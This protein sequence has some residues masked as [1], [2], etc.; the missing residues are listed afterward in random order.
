MEPLPYLRFF[1]RSNANL[2][3]YSLWRNV[4]PSLT[5]FSWLVAS[6]I[7]HFVLYRFSRSHASFNVHSK[8]KKNTFFW[9][10][11]SGS[12]LRL[13]RRIKGSEGSDRFQLP[14]LFQSNPLTI[15]PPRKHSSMHFLTNTKGIHFNQTLW[16]YILHGTFTFPG[17]LHHTLRTSL[18]YIFLQEVILQCTNLRKINH[19]EKLVLVLI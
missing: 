19:F 1:R 6:S 5:Y 2:N 13:P 15:Y 17:C 16:Q 7:E 3:E 18:S 11:C 14:K 9:E 8:P 10:S 4:S 12:D